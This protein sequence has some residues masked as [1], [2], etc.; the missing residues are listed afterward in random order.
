MARFQLI[1]VFSDVN[2][3]YCKINILAKPA[4]VTDIPTRLCTSHGFVGK[5]KLLPD[6]DCYLLF[7]K[8]VRIVGYLPPSGSSVLCIDSIV[9]IPLSV[10]KSIAEIR[11]EVIVHSYHCKAFIITIVCRHMLMIAVRK[12]L[13]TKQ[14]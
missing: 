13:E 10:E 9:L 12:M 5:L 7:I 1:L 3:N 11:I 6:S 4:I 2:N 14:N 8:D